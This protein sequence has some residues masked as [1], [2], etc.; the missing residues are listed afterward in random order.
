MIVK[1][2][3]YGEE[4]ITEKVLI[5]LINSELIQILKDKSQLGV[6]DE[7]N[8]KKGYSRYEHSLGVFLMLRKLGAN[9]DE[10][11]AG[12]LH[13]VSHTAFSH[14]IDWVSGDPTKESYQ[15]DHL[16]EIIKNSEISTILF[17]NGFDYKN[18]STPENFPL[19]EKPAPSLC[20]DRIDYSLREMFHDGKKDL[21]KKLY[22]NLFVKKNQIVFKNKSFAE[23]FAKEYT[24]LQVNSWGSDQA[25][26]RYHVLSEIIKKS[27]EDKI[28]SFSELNNSE[29]SILNKLKNSR[30]DYIIKN[31]NLLKK[32]FDIIEDTE[33]ISLKKKFRYIDPEVLVNGSY[34]NLSFLSEDYAK[35]LDK[36]KENSKLIKK[37]KIVE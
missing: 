6:P 8:F 32:G 27:L 12:L 15:D 16:L 25:R 14:V 23:N 18:I 10:Q 2:K 7:Y 36:E 22:D 17:E 28:I 3:I 13:D 11:V 19:L 21:S 20:A 1:D 33:G 5:D 31:L 24:S 4:K 30:N 37:V 9:L 34:E 35:L 26:L 29:T